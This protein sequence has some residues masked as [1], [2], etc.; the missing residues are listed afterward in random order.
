MRVCTIWLG[1][2]RLQN[3]ELT[4]HSS[5]LTFRRMFLLMNVSVDESV[6]SRKM[7]LQLKF[8]N[9]EAFLLLGKLLNV[10]FIFYLV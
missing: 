9:W 10:A 2:F 7:R 3:I 5:N 6:V 1:Y 8:H 4:E